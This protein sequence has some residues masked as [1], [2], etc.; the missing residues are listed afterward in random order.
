MDA[1]RVEIDG[2]P[3]PPRMVS[4]S[5]AAPA[6]FRRGEDAIRLTLEA[7][8]PALPAGS[9]R[10]LFRNAHL[11]GHSAYLANAL[12][13]ESARVAVT[14]QRRDRDQSELTIE[15]TLDD[16]SASTLARVLNRL[17]TAFTLP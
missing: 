13:P 6:L 4:V 3:L 9:H 10:L 14:A 5:L 2:R 12:V 7:A 8:L 11:A 1:L 15:Y 17:A 16:G